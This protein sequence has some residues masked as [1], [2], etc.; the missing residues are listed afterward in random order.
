MAGGQGREQLP[1][2][3]GGNL[4]VEPTGRDSAPAIALASLA[5][6]ARAGGATLGFFSSDH[7]IGDAAAFHTAVRHAIELAEAE[8]GLVTLGIAPTHPAHKPLRTRP[9]LRPPVQPRPPR[10]DAQG[11]RGEGGRRA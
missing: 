5:I 9:Q 11:G 8:D 10:A 2:L 3:P 7:R 4:L 6:H 1:E